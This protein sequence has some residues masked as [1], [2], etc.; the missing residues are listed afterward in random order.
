[1]EQKNQSINKI[2]PI[3]IAVTIETHVMW[4]TPVLLL[5]VKINV[6][7]V[8]THKLWLLVALSLGRVF[9]VWVVCIRSHS[10]IPC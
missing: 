3:K 5:N 9:H 6:V 8:D 2:V 4:P 1:M 7:H 10:S